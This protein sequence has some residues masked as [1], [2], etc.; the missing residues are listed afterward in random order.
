MAL[1]ATM[2]SCRCFSSSILAVS[3]LATALFTRVPP[4][5]QL[6]TLVLVT[7]PR[8]MAVCEMSRAVSPT[9][10]LSS[11]HVMLSYFAGFTALPSD[12]QP[13]AKDKASSADSR[14]EINKFIFRK[15]RS[16]RC[17]GGIPI[18]EVARKV[19]ASKHHADSERRRGRFASSYLVGRENKHLSV[20]FFWSEWQDLNLR[21]P[22]P[23][24]HYFKKNR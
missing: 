12:E 1:V 11:A 9:A 7:L 19:V 10:L 13:A 8:V 16:G 5:S 6:G 18:I 23:E 20:C 22:R 2:A 21:P 24:R 3:R 15:P 14:L 17:L 4:S